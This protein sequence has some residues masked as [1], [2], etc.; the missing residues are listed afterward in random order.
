M[1]TF[2]PFRLDAETES[3]WRAG[4]EI[5]LR[6]KTLAVLRYLAERPGRLVS[7][8]ALLEAV[9]PEAE[10]G[11]AALTVCVNEIRRALGDEAR[12]PRFV[13][14]VHRRG[15]RFVGASPAELPAAAPPPAIVGRQ[16]EL[17]ALRGWLDDARRGRRRVGFVTGP[18]GIGKTTLVEAFLAGLPGAQCLVGRG[19]CLDHYGAGEAYLPVLEALGRL[20]RG[21][22]G[23]R[24]VA[25]LL[26]HAP[27]WLVQMPGLLAPPETAGLQA[28]VLGATRERMLREMAEALEA[29]AAERPVVLLLEDLHWSDHSTLA[30]IGAVARRREPARLLLLGTFRPLDAIERGHPLGAVTQELAR[31]GACEELA[32][33]GLDAAEVGRYVTARLG[34]EAG[35]SLG[36]PVHRRTEGLPLFVVHVVDA[37]VQQGL[38]TGDA[39]VETAVPPS[40]RQMIE[41]QL[42]RLRPDARR[43]LEAASVAGGTFSAATLAAALQDPVED[44]EERCEA[45]ARREQFLRAAGVEEWPD[46]TVAAGYAFRHVLY[47][48]VLYE[49]LPAARRAGLHLAIAE[50][51]EAGHRARP[52]ERAAVLAVHF[53]R[54]RAAPRSVRHRLG[55]AEHALGQCAYPEAL[56]HLTRGGALLASLPEDVA[57]LDLELELQIARGTTLIGLRGAAAAEVEAVYVR[58]RELA[59]RLGDATRLFRA[60]WGLW[61]VSF[62]RGQYAAARTM[63]ERLLATA[64]PARRGQRLEAHH[65]LWATLGAMGE[66]AAL[67]PHVEHGL[68]LYDRAEHAPLALLYGGHDAGVCGWEH[69]ARAQWFLGYPDRALQSMRQAVRLAEVLGHPLTT[70]MALTTEAK[71]HYYR[72][73]L[74][75]ARESVGL[76]STL[77]IDWLDGAVVLACAD[78][79]EGRPGEALAEVFRRLTAR[80]TPRHARR[81]LVS[82][83]LLA[84]AACAS[85]QLDLA[86]QALDAIPEDHRET[87]LASEFERLHGELWRR[88]GRRAEAARCFRRAVEIA[89]TRGEGSLELRAATSLARLRAAEGRP[90]E[91]RAA[92]AGV[93]GRFTEGLDTADLR[94]ARELLEQ[95]S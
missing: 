60:L 13:E 39:D 49:R 42:D 91:A 55:A 83:L 32:L 81:N 3:L 31:H 93:Y 43:L 61:N 90:A 92:L 22:G 74:A 65:A 14:T 58:A 44:V 72:G 35:E 11:E 75:A 7:K 63:G 47:Q 95:T 76:A 10:V 67:L 68:A 41:Q 53:E 28:R 78:V 52:G 77:A 85:D 2:G 87:F 94:A 29:L 88:R 79:R 26:R 19:Q 25:L 16:P 50:R 12:A 73:E 9:W 38:V 27:T 21:P 34:G 1:L 40:L 36:G 15:Y 33:P 6:P 57:R 82:F 89:R 5:R 69:L 64:D 23:E 71:L 24:V 48:Q 80:E 20:A 51:E 59:E 70:V 62:G 56:E 84:E 30:L 66:T 17:A 37:L 86:R 45:L 4:E 46:G 8:D 54:G 18:A